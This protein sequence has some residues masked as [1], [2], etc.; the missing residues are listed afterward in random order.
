MKCDDCGVEL[1]TGDWPFCPHGKSASVV[2]PD[3]VPGG[4]WV[5]N[6]FATPR[7]FYSRSEHARALAA[8]NCEVRA[9]W[10]PGDQH[11]TRWDTVDLESAQS[12]VLR[13]MEG[14][15]ARHSRIANRESA[16]ITRTALDETFSEKDLDT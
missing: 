11:L 8:E 10:A 3:D 4:F 2:I 9:K 6:G 14:T 12:L 1:H 7:K 5:E 13:N 15:R 16:E